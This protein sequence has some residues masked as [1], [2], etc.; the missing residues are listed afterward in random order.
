MAATKSEPLDLDMTMLAAF[1][2]AYEAT[3]PA[4]GGP[5]MTSEDA[6]KVV[7]GTA[8]KGLDDYKKDLAKYKDHMPAY[9]YHFL[10]RSKPATHLQALAQLDDKELLNGM[11]QSCRDLIAYINDNLD[12]G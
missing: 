1:P 12:R 5:A 10:T 2:K 7:L 6:A 11:P 9:R 8:G 3:I 4:G